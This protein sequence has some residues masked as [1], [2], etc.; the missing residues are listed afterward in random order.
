MNIKSKIMWGDFCLKMNACLKVGLL[1]R[2]LKKGDLVL[3]VIS[4][5]WYHMMVADESSFESFTFLASLV[6]FVA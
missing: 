2:W 6:W 4:Q 3:V 1:I 5:C